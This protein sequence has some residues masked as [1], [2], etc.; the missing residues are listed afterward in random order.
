MLAG[1]VSIT[2]VDWWLSRWASKSASDQR[3]MYNFAIFIALVIVTMF[4]SVVRAVWVFKV[5]LDS[6]QGIFRRMLDA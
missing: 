2:L 4:I 6:S 5:M 3:P 1:Q